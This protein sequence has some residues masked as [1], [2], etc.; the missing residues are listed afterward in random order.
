MGVDNQ[1]IF[2]GMDLTPYKFSTHINDEGESEQS[3]EEPI[4]VVIQYGEIS[5][6]D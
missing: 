6:N 1:A 3:K 5:S 4:K 2:E